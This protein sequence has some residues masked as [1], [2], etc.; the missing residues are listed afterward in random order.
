MTPKGMN[1]ALTRAQSLLIVIG[2]SRIMSTDRLWDRFMKF[3]REGGGW[4]GLPPY[5]ELQWPDHLTHWKEAPAS[6]WTLTQPEKDILFREDE[7]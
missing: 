5:W 2:D 4:I 3:V 6:A 1:V 7:D